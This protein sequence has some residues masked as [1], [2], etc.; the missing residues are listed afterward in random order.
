[1]VETNSSSTASCSSEVMGRSFSK[2][3]VGRATVVAAGSVATAT[4]AHCGGMKA[5]G[6]GV[7]VGVGEGMAVADGV[8]EAG[9]ND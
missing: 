4:A 7:A 9:L 3:G 6:T 2:A 8:G 1:M 5:A